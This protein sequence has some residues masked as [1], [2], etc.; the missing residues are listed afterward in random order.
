MVL[1]TGTNYIRKKIIGFAGQ[2]L[3]VAHGMATKIQTP[4]WQKNAYTKYQVVQK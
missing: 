4:M 1:F 2:K 3:A